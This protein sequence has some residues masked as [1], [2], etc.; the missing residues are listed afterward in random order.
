MSLLKYAIVAAVGYYAGTP[1]GRRQ[2]Q[3]LGPKVSEL[4]RN[5]KVDELKERGRTVVGERASAAVNKVRRTSAN[6]S[7]AGGANA[8]TDPVTA[9]PASV[10][11]AGAGNRAAADDLPTAQTGVLP[12]GPAP[13]TVD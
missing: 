5:P 2:L 7:P 6:D 13:R 3:Q 12:P 11:V 1:A 4:S 10:P 8:T 9:G